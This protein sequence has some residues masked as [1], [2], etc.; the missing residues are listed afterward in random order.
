MQQ[1]I[2][3]TGT[4]SGF[5]AMAAR[6]LAR[7]GHHVYATMRDPSANGGAAAAAFAKLAG[8]EGLALET[9]A[10]DVTSQV[11]V[12]A[13]VDAVLK[14]AGRIDILIHNAGHMAFG[15]TEAFTPE[16]F[17]RLY[18]VNVI[19]TQRLNRAALPAMRA[20]EI[21]RAHV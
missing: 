2:L 19:G 15:P 16:Q 5:G 9:L 17:A 13:A 6:A 1:V 3:I 20:A 8:D 10:L 18:D 4:S 21:G 12:D 14:Q 7:A 11:S